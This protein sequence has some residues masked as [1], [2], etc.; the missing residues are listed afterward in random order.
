VITTLIV[1]AIGFLL[2]GWVLNLIRKGSVYVGYGSVLLIAIGANICVA[3]APTWLVEAFTLRIG[4]AMSGSL[5][6]FIAI[7]CI[8]LILT[9]VFK[10]ISG[11]SSRL[12]ILTQQLAIE[13]A[14]QGGTPDA[15]ELLSRTQKQNTER[16]SHTCDT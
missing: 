8:L 13:L 3:S 7:Y 10:E 15:D 16:L 1:D 6:V 14:R 11:I 9:Y 12:R 4:K 2:F 5:P